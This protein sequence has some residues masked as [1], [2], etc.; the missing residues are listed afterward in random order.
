[1]KKVRVGIIGVGGIGLG[2]HVKELLE[3]T[4]AEI[5]AI[6]DINSSTLE[7]CKRKDRTF[8]RKMLYKLP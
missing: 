4:D 8:A 5:T 6:C 3:C 2:K 7:K 1:M